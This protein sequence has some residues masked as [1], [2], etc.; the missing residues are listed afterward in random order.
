M[1]DKNAPLLVFVLA[2]AMFD[3]VGQNNVQVKLTF[4]GSVQRWR[5]LY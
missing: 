2:E 3:V 1:S 5:L 4:D